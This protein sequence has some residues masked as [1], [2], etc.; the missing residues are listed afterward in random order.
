MKKMK[1][2]VTV[3]RLIRLVAGNYCHESPES[4]SR[5]REPEFMMSV[6]HAPAHSLA[7]LS[8]F[9]CI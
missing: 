2:K 1:R 5:Q 6:T 9:S 3:V 7:E 4:Q 8:I